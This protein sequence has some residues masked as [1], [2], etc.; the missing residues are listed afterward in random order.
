MSNDKNSVKV[1]IYG[2]EFTVR[3]GSDPEYT[4]KVA[5][6]VNEKMVEVEGSMQSKSTMRVAILAAMNVA[7]ELFQTRDELNNFKEE[8]GERSQRLL[9]KV[10]NSLSP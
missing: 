1:S 7:D 8:I 6:Y 10:T 3:G 5:N 2:M 9:E 4:S